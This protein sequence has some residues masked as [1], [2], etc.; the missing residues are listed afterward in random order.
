[1]GNQAKNMSP[2]HGIPFFKGVTPDSDMFPQVDSM[3]QFDMEI[4]C[5]ITMSMKPPT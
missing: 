1:M 3:S 5:I 2:C 4:V